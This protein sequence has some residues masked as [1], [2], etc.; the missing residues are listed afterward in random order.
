MLRNYEGVI[1]TYTEP[2]SYECNA[3]DRNCAECNLQLKEDGAEEKAIGIEKLISD[4]DDTL[5]L[6]P[7]DNE[8]AERNSHVA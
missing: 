4:W 1:T 8:R 2:D 7:E 5:S 6:T 3:C